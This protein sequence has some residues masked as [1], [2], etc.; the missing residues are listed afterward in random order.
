MKRVVRWQHFH[1]N[2]YRPRNSYWELTSS[3]RTRTRLSTCSPLGLVF[4]LNIPACA[5]PLI[6]V[7]VGSAAAETARTQSALPAVWLLFVF[8]LALSAPLVLAVLSRWG[9]NLLDRIALLASRAPRWTGMVLV[10]LGG[11]S[12]WLAF[13]A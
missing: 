12:I 4:G 7:L 2:V 6:A 13:K 10:L 3:V 9:R 5:A 11:W 8:G 1:S